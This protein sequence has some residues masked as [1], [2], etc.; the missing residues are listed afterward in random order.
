MNTPFGIRTIDEA[1]EQNW[2]ASLNSIKKHTIKGYIPPLRW[3]PGF[4]APG[5][6]ISLD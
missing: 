1:E 5:T 4:L 3:L 6:L 2:I